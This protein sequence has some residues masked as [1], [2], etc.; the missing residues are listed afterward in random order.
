[1]DLPAFARGER[2]ALLGVV[3]GVAGSV[4]PW[5]GTASQLLVDPAGG[6]LIVLVVT[7]FCGIVVFLRPW[8]VGDRLLVATGG[9]IVLGV[10]GQRAGTLLGSAGLGIGLFLSAFGGLGLLLGGGLDYL[11]PER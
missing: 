6:A 1:M 8:T 9:A 4:L 5:H 3:A 10:V 2:L 7:T 11:W